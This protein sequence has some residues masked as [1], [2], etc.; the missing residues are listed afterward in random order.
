LYVNR[1]H[2]I[3]HTIPYA[4]IGRPKIVTSPVKTARGIVLAKARTTITVV[5]PDRIDA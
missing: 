3:V 5:V 1:I 4:R 2:Y